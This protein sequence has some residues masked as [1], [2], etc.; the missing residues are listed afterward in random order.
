MSLPPRRLTNADLSNAAFPFMRSQRIE[1]AGVDCIALRVSFTGDLGW[2]LHCAEADQ[3]R[4]A[5]DADL[6]VRTKGAAQAEAAARGAG[7]AR[8]AAEDALPPLREEEAIAGAILQRLIVQR[9]TLNDQE[10]R[11]LQLIETLK[12]APHA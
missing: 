11:A 3:A 8:I 6:T 1:V 10:A 4:L 12:G 5:A 9:D 2:E 7:K